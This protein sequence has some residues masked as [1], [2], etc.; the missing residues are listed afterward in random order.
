MN[1]TFVR[2]AIA[3]GA[4]ALAT[5]FGIHALSA[6]PES[7][8]AITSVSP[9]AVAGPDGATTPRAQT[10]SRR[11]EAQAAP[12][13]PMD[14]GS[15]ARKKDKKKDAEKD[16]EGKSSG[17]KD[18]PPEKP[19][20][21]VVKNFTVQEGLFNFY[22][23]DGKTLL[24]IRPDQYDRYYMVSLSRLSGVGETDL[25]GNHMLGNYP[26]QFHKVG[27]NVQ[28][29][30]K[31]VSFRADRDPDI[32]K[33]V[34]RSFSDS[35]QGN[36]KLESQP[37]P[38]RKSDLVDTAS[39]FLGDIERVEQYT[40]EE[41]HS[42]YK[43][44]KDNSYVGTIRTFPTNVEIETV[45]HF[46][47]PRSKVFMALPDNRSMQIRYNFS[48]SA[49]PEGNYRPRIGDDR[50]GHF[51]TTV[52]DYSTD[53]GPTPYVRYVE[54]W[55]LE[56]ADPSAKISA[57]REPITYYIDNS[58]P[59]KYRAAVADGILLWNKAFERAG[60]RDAI[61]VKP[62]PDDPAWDTADARYSSVR[63][64][65]TTDSVYAIGPSLSNPFTGQIY[66]ADIGFSESMTRWTRRE[67]R[68]L[69]DPL[70]MART[71]VAE[72][73]ASARTAG[74]EVP[75][76]GHAGIGGS[77]LGDPGRSCNIGGE[78]YRQAGF[79]WGI[80]QARGMMVPGGAEED[81][82][83]RDFLISIA[84]HEV[85]HTL[86][87]KHNF[88]ASTLQSVEDL[89]NVAK[90]TEMGLTGSVMEYTP[91]NLAP[92]GTKQ[93]QYW[94]TTLGTYDYW[95]IEYAYKPIDAQ[96][97]EGELPEL[98]KIAS[99]SPDPALAYASDEDAVGFQSAPVGMD[100]RDH[101]WDI[102][103]DPVKYY[104][105]RVKLAHELWKSLPDKVAREGEGYQVVRRAF[106]QGLGEYFP[107]VTSMTK[108]VGGVMN[109]R[110]HVGDP[111]GRSPYVPVP[112]A[113]QR[114][115]LQFLNTYVFS[116]EAFQ[117]NPDLIN[118][119]AIERYGEMR[120]YLFSPR[121][122]YP[123]HET[124]LA[125][126][127]IPLARL[128]HPLILKRLQDADARVAKGQ[129]YVGM[130]EVFSALR[131]GIWSEISPGGSAGAGST[132]IASKPAGAGAST[133]DINV[134]IPKPR[135]S[136]V[137]ISSFRRALQRRELGY[138]ASL[139]MDEIPEAPDE[140]VTLARAD[141][142]ELKGRIAT[143]LKSAGL[144]PA[145]KAHLSESQSVIDQ[146]LDA[147]FLRKI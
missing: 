76:V 29:I 80:L 50:V 109:N 11:A 31:N 6:S 86:G 64:F 37:H 68:E 139:A 40:D 19:F 102:G 85:G 144:D 105:E 32:E 26:V 94:Q 127:S 28:L 136:K 16:A 140:A 138:L 30:I 113:E 78:A 71:I 42:P 23:K 106:S 39:L 8:T 132:V 129:D 72:T 27:K 21:D 121:R 114:R 56:K 116:P 96:N 54:R 111:G 74:M 124:I 123:L 52:A 1:R 146:A 58:I 89:Q 130:A 44:D 60:F 12:S 61:V 133:A 125:I 18:E 115:A 62:Q 49:L 112:A 35:I 63:W 117:F 17:K 22:R 59:H 93:G 34:E 103:N 131:D 122:D 70:T 84:A 9:T 73:L 110:D 147:K 55:K 38:D 83:I 137:E 14:A 13:S 4:L 36:A 82:Y 48:I 2:T 24:E 145:V 7:S 15:V 33:A 69:V 107:A 142:M 81:A 79:G 90:T 99:R 53:S 135:P 134:A 97:P 3:A 92:A 119:L 75:V 20:A 5:G 77:L 67:F 25:L 45:M 141:L 51:I 47:N 101:Q 10:S 91:V 46:V 41:L 128:Y 108:Y 43:P 57:P 66:D 126:Q 65:V 95:A 98:K 100:P 118:D 88:R 104:T 120:G 143:A 87:L